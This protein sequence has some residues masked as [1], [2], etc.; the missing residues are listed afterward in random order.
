M[1]LSHHKKSCRVVRFSPSGDDLHTAS[2]DKSFNTID[3]NTGTIKRRVKNAHEYV[4][5]VCFYIKMRVKTYIAT[6]P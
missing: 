4:I 3:L 5:T 2:K 1:K 6:V